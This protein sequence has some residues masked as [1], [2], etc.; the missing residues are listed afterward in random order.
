MPTI[1]LHK[2]ARRKVPFVLAAIIIASCAAGIAAW[3]LLTPS[4]KPTVVSPAEMRQRATLLDNEHNYTLEQ[5]ELLSYMQSNPP[6]TD[7]SDLYWMQVKIANL[8]ASNQDL[9]TALEW[10]KKA[11]ST[12]GKPGLLDTVGA[13]STEA[14]LGNNGAAIAYYKEAITLSDPSVPENNISEF[15]QAIK[16]L[17]G[18][19]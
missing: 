14:R 9:S 18:Q 8:Y 12:N 3:L 15:Q 19:P 13:A 4:D 11:R 2:G 7:E 5:S 6:H 10:Y 1:E 16:L 17:G